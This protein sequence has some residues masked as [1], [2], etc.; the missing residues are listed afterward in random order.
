[1]F[2]CLVN[3]SGRALLNAP[4]GVSARKEQTVGF[5]NLPSPLFIEDK[6]KLTL[7]SMTQRKE[8]NRS[9]RKVVVF[10]FISPL[11]SVAHASNVCV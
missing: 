7:L 6:G 9:A 3:A 8:C 11:N 1:M 2:D 5:C 10:R 4:H